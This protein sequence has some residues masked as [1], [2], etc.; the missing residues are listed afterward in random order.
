MI[1]FFRRGDVVM[2]KQ[3]FLCAAAVCAMLLP[4]L[5]LA[6]SATVGTTSSASARAKEVYTAPKEVIELIRDEG[7]KRSQV[8]QHLSYLTDVIGGRL[9]NSPNMKRANEWTRDTMAKWGMKNAKLEPW[10]PFGRGW[11]LKSF[12]AEVNTPTSFPVIAYPKA[13]ST[14]TKGAVSS[15]VIFLD[16]NKEEDFAKYKGQLRGKIVLIARPREV[17]A[18]WEPLAVRYTD[19]ELAKMAAAPMP[20][21]PASPAA[22][23]TPTAEQQ[24]RLR[25]LQLAQKILPF[26]AE[27]GAAVLVDNSRIGSGGTLF[28][29]SASVVPLPAPAGQTPQPGGPGNAANRARNAVYNKDNESRIIPQITMASEDYNRLVRMIK[30]GAKPTMTVNIQTQFHDED[31]MGYNTVAEIP[32]SDPKLKEELVMLG[33]HLDSWHS[34]TGAT[35]NA[36]G[37]AVMMEAARIL[38]AT[39]LKPRRT[40]RVALWSGEEQGLNGSREYVQNLLRLRTMTSSLP[41]TISTMERARSAASICRAIRWCGHISKHGSHLLPISVRRR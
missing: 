6:Q 18:E 28:V 30:S 11:S 27:E 20:A 31:L 3:K 26:V 5:V 4:S 13:W 9:T 37:C 35:D 10:G 8:M 16:I 17:K 2:F 33:G 14:S 36:A 39:G 40:V 23:A 34:G 12:A 25:Q 32:G 19:A 1:R 41:T 22:P 38:V 29:S 21:P 7:L 15:E 24:E